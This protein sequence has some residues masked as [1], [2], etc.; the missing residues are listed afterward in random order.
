ME[1]LSEVQGCYNAF[2]SS[3]NSFGCSNSEAPAPTTTAAHMPAHVT[4]RYLPAPA[5]EGLLAAWL[6]CSLPHMHLHLCAKVTKAKAE[7]A[8]ARAIQHSDGHWILPALRIAG[9]TLLTLP[10]LTN[11]SQELE[12]CRP[13]PPSLT[14]TRFGKSLQDFTTK[15]PTRSA[16]HWLNQA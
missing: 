14:F 4:S 11:G 1:S 16:P 7:T 2:T 12:R 5:F 6:A 9:A 3:K 8:G 13:L 15:H 10:G